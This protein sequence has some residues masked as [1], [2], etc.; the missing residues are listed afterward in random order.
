MAAQGTPPAQQQQVA[1][2]Q[3]AVMALFSRLKDVGAGILSDV[4]SSD[5]ALLGPEFLNVPILGC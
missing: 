5:S 2:T 3:N 1:A 4:R